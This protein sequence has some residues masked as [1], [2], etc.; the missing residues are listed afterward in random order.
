MLYTISDILQ[1]TNYDLNKFGT[2]QI[3]ALEIYGRKGKPYLKDF[4]DSTERPA[5]PEEIVRQLY[6]HKLIYTYKYP[7]SLIKVEHGVQ[8]GHDIHEK[9]ADIVV[10]DKDDPTAA[11]IIVEVKKPKRK[12]GVEQLKAYCNATGAVAAVWTNGGAEVI[13]RREHLKSGATT[14][15]EIS[16]IP[17]ADQTMREVIGERVTIDELERRNK[18]VKEKTTLTEI[19]KDLENLVLANAG[20]DAF[21]EI[22]KLVYAKLFDEYRATNGNTPKERIVEFRA[23]S[24]SESQI[25]DRISQLFED[26]KTEWKGAFRKS[27]AINLEPDA[28]QICVSFLQDIKLFNSNLQVI[29]DAFEYLTVKIAKGD[30]G[31]VSRHAPSLICA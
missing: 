1:N 26:A 15:S 9:R 28:L 13:M 23:D 30:K 6:L 29:D 10:F 12:D 21:E 7:R 11:Y 8:M 3:E 19:I 18:L 16:D 22:F 17:R 27:E 5:K 25:Y 20:V 31:Q 2:D 4:V 14:Y 24:E